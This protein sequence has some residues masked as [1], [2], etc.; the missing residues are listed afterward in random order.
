MDNRNSKNSKI[1]FALVTKDNVDS[2]IKNLNVSQ[3]SQKNSVPRLTIKKNANIFSELLHKIS[4]NAFL[5]SRFSNNL[6]PVKLWLC[7]RKI[8]RNILGF[9]AQSV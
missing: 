5:Q 6:K 1:G 7:L 4:I 8:K 2:S 3:T 9:S